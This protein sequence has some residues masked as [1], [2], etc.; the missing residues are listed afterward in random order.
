MQAGVPGCIRILSEF[1]SSADEAFVVALEEI[2]DFVFGKSSDNLGNVTPSELVL[3]SEAAVKSVGG[4]LRKR[5]RFEVSRLPMET[6]IVEVLARLTRVLFWG[7]FESEGMSQRR[8]KKKIE[9]DIEELEG[10]LLPR[11]FLKLLVSPTMLR[12][13]LM[14][15]PWNIFLQLYGTEEISLRKP[16][17]KVL[18]TEVVTA[19]TGFKANFGCDFL[20]HTYVDT[21][22]SVLEV[23]ETDVVTDINTTL[24]NSVCGTDNGSRTSLDK[25]KT[26]RSDVKDG[27]FY[28]SHNNICTS[29]SAIDSCKI[30]KE[31]L[32]S[33]THRK[34]LAETL[35]KSERLNS[36]SS[37]HSLP[38]YMLTRRKLGTGLGMK[39]DNE[40]IEFSHIGEDRSSPVSEDC[41]QS[42]L[43]ECDNDTDIL[44]PETP[45]KKRIRK[46]NGAIPPS[47]SRPTREGMILL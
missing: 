46:E 39:S 13:V 30:Q 43:E 26:H 5:K 3:R 25:E 42:S 34:T 45:V 40:S 7:L 2:H 22:P 47:P 27:D 8:M 32:E 4:C 14:K 21:N 37:R 28:F 10:F 31:L 29:T 6:V 9:D 33:K 11:F 41:V 15:V 36:T 35:R 1:K 19:L 18:P 44:A 17:E 12:D 23:K 38:T 24:L 20:F 16:R